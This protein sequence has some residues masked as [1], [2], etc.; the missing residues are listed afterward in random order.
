VTAADLRSRSKSYV[1]RTSAH[2]RRP[3][4]TNG[5][6]RTVKTFPKNLRGVVSPPP[7]VQ[8]LCE[9]TPTE[10]TSSRR[11]TIRPT[12]DRTNCE[13]LLYPIKKSSGRDRS[14]SQP[15]DQPLGAPAGAGAGSS[16]APARRLRRPR[17]SPMEICDRQ[18]D[19]SP[20][21]ALVAWSSPL[22]APPYPPPGFDRT[23]A[24]VSDLGSGPRDGIQ[25]GRPAAGQ[26]HSGR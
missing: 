16:P 8:R 17:S 3:A 18:S 12:A 21:R 20:A 23:S 25:A 1:A 15:H 6:Q 11:T 10:V 22:P 13:E 9:V 14:P 19:R 24:G 2:Q 4:R 5:H 26:L 7:S